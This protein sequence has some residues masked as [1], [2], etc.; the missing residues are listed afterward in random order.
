MKRL[1]AGTALAA[2][3]VVAAAATRP[4]WVAPDAAQAQAWLHAA[5]DGRDAQAEASLAR[6]SD[7]G[8]VDARHAYA[9]LLAHR[10]DAASRRRLEMVLSDG[11]DAG[12]ALAATQLAELLARADA[13]RADDARVARLLAQ[14]AAGHVP[15]ASRLQA[16]RVPDP[17]RAATLMAEAANGGDAPAMFL[18]ANMLRAGQGVP[19]DDARALALYQAAADADYAPA[20]QALTIA[21]RYGELGLQADASQSRLMDH[22]A[23]EALAHATH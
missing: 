16:L 3:L 15:A 10:G 11:A 7:R 20:I 23:A 8:S 14:G 6:W 1:V 21:Y 13:S 17:V 12:D 5:A 4:F 9:A 22:E 2:T 19:R 18:Y